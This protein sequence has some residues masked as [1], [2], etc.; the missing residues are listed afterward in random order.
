[1]HDGGSRC[2]LPTDQARLED[3]LFK[4]IFPEGD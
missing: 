3:L 4:P 2:L 1:M